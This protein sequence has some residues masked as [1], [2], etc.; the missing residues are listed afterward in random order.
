MV[1]G[2]VNRIMDAGDLA[3]D[4]DLQQRLLGVG[5]HAEPE[6]PLPI[7]ASAP[8][9]RVAHVCR[10]ARQGVEPSDGIAEPL[11][12]AD[13]LPTRWGVRIAPSRALTEAPRPEAA[14]REIFAI[15]IA[16]RVGRTALVV[17]TFDTKGPELRY[18]GDRL[19]DV[20]IQVR[21]VDLSTSG[22]VSRADVSPMQVASMHPGGSNAVFSGDRGQAV[23]AMAD[24]FARWI[25]RERGIGG[26]ISAGGWGGAPVP[27]PRTG[28]PPGG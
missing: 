8:R 2:R 28:G 6:E 1:N 16:A 19:R 24:A 3:R 15:P 26:I 20:G 9:R 22:K 11:Y 5:R 14:T 10:V 12:R 17:G 21:T 23:G 4:R 25:D 27:P 18:I 7:V 13:S